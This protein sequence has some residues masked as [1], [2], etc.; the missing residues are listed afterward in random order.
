[1]TS[2]EEE[3]GHCEISVSFHLSFEPVRFLKLAFCNTWNT[4]K[5]SARKSSESSE[6][7]IYFFK[8]AKNSVARSFFQYHAQMRVN[9]DNF[10]KSRAQGL[11]DYAQIGDILHILA[12][13]QKC[14]C[15]LQCR[16]TI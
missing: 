6:V 8:N 11:E 16:E 5:I 2:R 4:Y 15:R 10:F 7:L 12:T 3:T 9:F 14:K 1:M 13:L